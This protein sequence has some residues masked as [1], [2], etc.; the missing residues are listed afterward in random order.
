MTLPD[1]FPSGDSGKSTFT[2]QMSLIY[3]PNPIST[4]DYI[5]YSEVLK[6]NALSSMQELLHVMKTKGIKMKSKYKPCSKIVNEA[7][8]LTPEVAGMF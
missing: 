7:N 8:F 3:S 6:Q 1:L 2:R 4:A 5:K